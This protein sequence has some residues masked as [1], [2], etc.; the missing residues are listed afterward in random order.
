MIVPIGIGIEEKLVTGRT[1]RPLV[2]GRSE[3]LE[4][5]PAG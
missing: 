1:R 5:N 3:S 2:L 4:T